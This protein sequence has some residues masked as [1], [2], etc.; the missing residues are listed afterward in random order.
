VP[1]AGQVPLGLL[2]LPAGARETGARLGSVDLVRTAA[3]LVTGGGGAVATAVLAAAR[4]AGRAVPMARST[5]RRELDLADPFGVRDVVRTWARVV[6]ADGGHRAVVVNADA[7]T[8]A[9]SAE[10]HED[11]AYAVNAAGPAV[12]AAVCAEVGAWLL[13][14][15]SADVFGGPG[16]APRAA[17]EVPHPVSAYGRTRLA[18]EQ[19]VREIHPDGSWVVRTGWVYG[20]SPQDVVGAAAAGVRGAGEVVAF[21]DRHGSPTWAGDLGPA[22]VALALSDVEPG[23]LH[24]ASLGAAS[25]YDLTRETYAVLG[26]DP[27]LVRP[28]AASATGAPRPSH[29]VLSPA[30]WDAT[31]LPPLPAWQDGLRRALRG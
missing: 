5:D 31:G 14:V 4:E 26:A 12:L 7:W 13:H 23:M 27:G 21:D 22:L 29:A 25:F 9:D 1:R 3:L 16:S 17:G 30:S 15:S 18:G 6:R 10:E 19:A 20:P 8:D 24:A 11:D 2:S 28:V